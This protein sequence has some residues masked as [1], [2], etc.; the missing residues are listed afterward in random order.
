MAGSDHTGN[1]TAGGGQHP[2]NFAMRAM[3]NNRMMKMYA[4]GLCGLLAVFIVSHW[5]RQLFVYL[6]RSSKISAAMGRPFVLV[7]R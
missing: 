6:Q 4:A 5:T 7:S 3:V 1:S 2:P